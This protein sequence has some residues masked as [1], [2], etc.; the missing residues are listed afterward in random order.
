M[1]D[2][3]PGRLTCGLVDGK[4]ASS[5]SAAVAGGEPAPDPDP[6]LA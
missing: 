2:G 5:V 1:G 4:G 3:V 6:L